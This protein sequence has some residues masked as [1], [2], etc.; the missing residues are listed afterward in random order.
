LEITNKQTHGRVYDTISDDLD[1]P[2]SLPDSLPFHPAKELSVILPKNDLGQFDISIDD[3]IG[4]TPDLHDNL[5]RVSRAIP[6]AIQTLARP[7]DSNDIIPRKD[8]ISLKKIKAEGRIE[9]QKTVLGWILNTR[10][11]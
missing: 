1:H 4:L 8:I 3:T 11:L 5:Q 6:L 7:L 9:E 10:S 2:L